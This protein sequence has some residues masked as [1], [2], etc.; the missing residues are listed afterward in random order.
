MNGDGQAAPD[1]ADLLTAAE[2]VRDEALD[3]ARELRAL[4]AEILAAHDAATASTAPPR[5]RR[6]SP[7]GASRSTPS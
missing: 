1:P 7:G 5:S 2:R 6:A 3:E 4:A